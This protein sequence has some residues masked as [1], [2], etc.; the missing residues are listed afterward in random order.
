[1]AAET[2]SQYAVDAVC[3]LASVFSRQSDRKKQF[4]DSD[5]EGTL[6]LVCSKYF[7]PLWTG[8]M[9]RRINSNG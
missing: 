8:F 7:V 3:S 4:G 9:W 6:S 2:F 1:V 5:V